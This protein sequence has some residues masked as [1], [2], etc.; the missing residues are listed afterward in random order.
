MGGVLVRQPQQQHSVL[1]TLGLGGHQRGM[2]TP[3]LGAHKECLVYLLWQ[4]W[5]GISR[6]ALEAS[7]QMVACRINGA[8]CLRLPQPTPI[9]DGL[10]VVVG[11]MSH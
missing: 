5:Q 10:V 8:T 6:M 2:S 1:L 3:L 4:H 11:G 9:D 7:F